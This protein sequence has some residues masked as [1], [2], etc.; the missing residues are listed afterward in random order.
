ML[1]SELIDTLQDTLDNE[2]DMPVYT[3][4]DTDT[5]VCSVHVDTRD[6]TEAVLILE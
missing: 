2:G 6:T 5:Q 3:R 4:G 1:L